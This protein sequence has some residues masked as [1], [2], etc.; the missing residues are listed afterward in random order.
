MFTSCCGGFFPTIS[1]LA[2]D[3]E[4]RFEG[5]LGPVIFRDVVQPEAKG[6]DEFV[7]LGN[8]GG[9]EFGRQVSHREGRLGN[10]AVL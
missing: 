9:P 6:G 1:E 4:C 7:R 2:G 10:Y 5:S 8:G 3:F